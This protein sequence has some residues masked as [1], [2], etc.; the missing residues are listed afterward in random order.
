MGSRAKSSKKLR[1]R[2]KYRPGLVLAICSLAGLLVS[3]LLA[4]FYFETAGEVVEGDTRRFDEAALLMLDEHAPSWLDG[5]VRAV[6]VL[7]YYPVV[8]LLLAAVSYAFYRVRER[9]CAAILVV[10]TLEGIT[11]AT[12]LKAAFGRPRPALSDSGYGAPA[13]YAFPS[14]HAT[15]A[16]GFYGVLALLLA[17]RLSGGWR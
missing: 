6:T 8:V 5:P 11:L 15:V 14:G 9:A 12:A 2:A 1:V 7:G 17:W 13:S 4:A 16:V 3:L 10:S